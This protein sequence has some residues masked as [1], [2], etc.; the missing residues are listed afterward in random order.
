MENAPSIWSLAFGVALGS[1]PQTDLT[2][3]AEVRDEA[4]QKKGEPLLYQ[5]N[6]P[7]HVL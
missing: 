5:I 2:S 4:T 6:K 1:E 7:S 3:D